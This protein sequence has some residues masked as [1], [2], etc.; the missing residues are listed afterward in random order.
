MTTVLPSHAELTDIFQTLSE[1]WETWRQSF[2]LGWG[3]SEDKTLLSFATRAVR[4]GNPSLLG[5][6]LVCFALS[7]GD[8]TRYL[9]PV[10]NWILSEDNFTG[11]AYDFQCMIALGICLLSALHPRRAWSVFRTANTRLQLAGLHKTHR[12]SKAADAVFWQIFGADRWLSLM[13]GLPYSIPDHLCDLHIPEPTES[14]LINFHYQHL[15]VLTGR[16]IDSLQSSTSASLSDLIA[17]EE[18]IDAITA[19]LPPGYLDISQITTGLDRPHQSAR[20][21]R[22]LQINQL[23]AFL[24]LPHFLQRREPQNE[25]YQSGPASHYGKNACVNSA[26]SFLEA[27][28]ALYDLDP[29]TAQVDNSMKLTAFSVLAAGVVLYLD[30]IS[31]TKR[32]EHTESV[33]VDIN[34]ICRTTSILQMCSGDQVDS[35]CGQ[36]HRALHELVSCCGTMDQG[37]SREIIVPC[38]GAITISRNVCDTTET[39]DETGVRDIALESSGAEFQPGP[40]DYGSAFDNT[41]FIPPT[42]FEDMLFSYEGP[43]DSHE[44][45]PDPFHQ[46]ENF[47]F[48]HMV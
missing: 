44:T 3:E 15:T 19:K 7:T 37:S 25:K 13:I 20:F 47:S 27:F 36:C 4:S 18:K 16:V 6:L 42:L 5:S 11:H 30:V 26:R 48:Y 41:D 38:F 8:H 40:S 31:N 17:V 35:L 39:I 45:S 10:E 9:G 24:Y 29:T 28:L 32:A 12:K 14:T 22:I 21:Y 1:W 2:G 46:D 43:W 33:E 23:K 34:L